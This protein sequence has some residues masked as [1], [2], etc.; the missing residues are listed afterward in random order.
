MARSTPVNAGY[1]IINGTATGS[2]GSRVDVWIE[3]KVITQ[4]IL[5][6]T[7]TLRVI[8]YA[9]ATFSSTTKYEIAANYGYV[10]YDNSNKQYLSTTYDFSGY[11]INKFGDYTYTITH[12]NNG[13]KS[14]AIQ[15]AFTTRSSYIS[16]GNVS[17]TVALP[18]IARA[19]V[20]IVSTA[21]MGQQTTITLEPASESFTHTL[22]WIFGTSS[23]NIT[24]QTA[25]RTIQYVFPDNLAAEVPNSSIGTLQI[26]CDTYQGDT[27]IGSRTI[28]I[29]LSVPLDM[30]PTGSVTITEQ[31]NQA[32]TLGFFVQH[33]STLLIQT[34]AT[35]V[36]G[37]T[38]ASIS[39]VIAGNVYE[40]AEVTAA[41]INA[42]GQVEV[43]TTITDSRQR[44][45][46]VTTT[47]YVEAY[48][49]PQIS[50]Y[51]V[52]RCTADGTESRT[53][54]Y[55]K[56][57][58]SGSISA[59]QQLNANT[60][61]IEYKK[62]SASS[63]TTV[64]GT[65]GYTA[66]ISEILSD[67]DTASA[68]DFTLSLMDSFGSTERSTQVAVASVIMNLRPDGLG[69]AFGKVSEKAGMEI[70]FPVELTGNL[71]LIDAI[72]S[73]NGSALVD[74]IVEEG[75]SG[76]WQYVKFASGLIF[77]YAMNFGITMPA[78]EALGSLYWR[79]VSIS[80]PLV[81]STIY[82]SFGDTGAD[83][84]RWT[85]CN[86]NWGSANINVQQYSMNTNGNAAYTRLQGF[87]IGRWKE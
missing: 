13:T 59:L 35:G 15:G 81:T 67:I 53:G 9:A 18:T 54:A 42:F 61:K 19:T 21:V 73:I 25:E 30:T 3:Y 84:A 36:Y 56:V 37:S 39:T 49:Y 23:G 16:G 62:V 44:Q 45:K 34:T 69:I 50:T 71:N 57:E 87:V 4:D 74:Y 33:I 2:N 12:N 32:V 17:G 51:R 72:F 6:N 27:L 52:V 64:T 31:N 68:Y 10:G 83:Y 26:I 85:R 7:S 63:Y 5:A 47:I 58:F 20:P 11:Q 14:V 38:I 28:S 46:V 8:L 24:G 66:V 22:R 82:V 55:A 86:G 43:V 60:Y 1:T 65:P 48:E 29:A 78:W 77:L 41:D 75:Y 80:I 40:G 79:T 70:A 76:S